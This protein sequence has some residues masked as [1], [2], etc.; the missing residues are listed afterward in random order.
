MLGMTP[1]DASIAEGE[2]ERPATGAGA[3]LSALSPQTFSFEFDDD[4]VK[5]VTVWTTGHTCHVNVRY[6]RE[7][8]LHEEDH[9]FDVASPITIEQTR[10]GVVVRATRRGFPWLGRKLVRKF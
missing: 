7:V 4:L 1:W 3:T 5:L 2:R 6:G 8:L 9:S 10:Y